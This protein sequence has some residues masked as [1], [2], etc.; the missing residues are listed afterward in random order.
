MDKASLL[1]F[2]VVLN[3]SLTHVMLRYF[4]HVG[5]VCADE[6][7]SSLPAVAHSL[8]QVY[9]AV[10]GCQVGRSSLRC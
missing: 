2:S 6:A 8:F 9:E 10:A 1:S 4:I 3:T 7:I 5:F